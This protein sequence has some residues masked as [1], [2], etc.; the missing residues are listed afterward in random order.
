[1]GVAINCDNALSEKE[2]DSSLNQHDAYK[3]WVLKHYPDSIERLEQQYQSEILNNPNLISVIIPIHNPKPKN[4]IE[5]VES[6][7]GQSYPYFEIILVNDSPADEVLELLDKISL[8]SKKIKVINSSRSLGLSSAIKSV[9]ELSQGKFLTVLEQDDL[10]WPNTLYEFAQ[11]L[12][13]KPDVE[14]IYCDEDKVLNEERFNHFEPFF[15]PDWNPDFLLSINYIGHGSLWKR[16]LLKNYKIHTAY[17]YEAEK[18]ALNLWISRHFDRESIYHIEKVLYSWRVANSGIDRTLFNAEPLLIQQKELLI[19]HMELLGN[20]KDDI[21]VTPKVYAPSAYD[22]HLAVN[23]KPLVSIVIPTKNQYQILKRCVDSLYS[24]TQYKNFEVII[25]DTGSRD[26]K[27]LSWYNIAKEKYDNFR[28][29]EFEERIFSYS[30]SCNFGAAKAKGSFLV[31]L[32]NDTEIIQNDWLEIMLGAAQQKDVGCVGVQLWYPGHRALQHTGIATGVNG[33]ATN[34]M[35]GILAADITTNV[36]RYY[37]NFTHT[38]TAVTAACMMIRT[39]V[40]K[41]VSGFDTNFRVT[42]N[43][44]DLC[45]RVIEKGYRN[46]YLSDVELIHHESI[47][48]G[49]LD[50]EHREND[51]FKKSEKLFRSCWS[52]Y[53]EKDPNFNGN[54]SRVTSKFEIPNDY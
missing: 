17:E 40:F 14:F 32:N 9:I 2:I 16:E 46:I 24:R 38:I 54:F 22:V 27:V 26:S 10:F 42:F 47:S 35:N 34:L 31:M 39:S 51:E 48:V 43:D 20:H 15:K 1:M 19:E 5:A 28:V 25:V 29:Y 37:T 44:V 41:E 21:L 53:V 36:Q 52:S 8:L 4:L 13:N 12:H 18:W 33:V 50:E 45:L 23:D 7:L 30:N 6:V 3:K 49:H 11:V